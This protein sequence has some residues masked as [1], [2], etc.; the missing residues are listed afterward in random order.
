MPFSQ[1]IVYAQ[2]HR[3]VQAVPAR[4]GVPL[5]PGSAICSLLFKD[6]WLYFADLWFAV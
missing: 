2:K 5:H 4:L 3:K 6:F 1:W